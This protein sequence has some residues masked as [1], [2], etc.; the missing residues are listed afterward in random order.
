M[1]KMVEWYDNLAIYSLG[2]DCNIFPYQ[3]VERIND[4][5]RKYILFP[6][7][8]GCIVLNLHCVDLTPQ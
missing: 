8:P 7:A 4:L 5:I 6:M 1:S 3:M 2:I